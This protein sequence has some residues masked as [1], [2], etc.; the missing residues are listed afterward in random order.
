MTIGP[1][2]KTSVDEFNKR[3]A[4]GHKHQNNSSEGDDN[5]DKDVNLSNN[6]T[7]SESITNPVIQQV[8]STTSTIDYSSPARII[9][10]ERVIEGFECNKES[11]ETVEICVPQRDVGEEAVVV[12]D[13]GLVLAYYLVKHQKRFRFFDEENPPHVVDIGAGTGVVGLVAAGLGAKVTL[14]DLPRILPL[15]EEGILANKSVFQDSLQGRYD[16][17]FIRA[18]PLN[19]GNIGEVNEVSVETKDINEKKVV[20]GP[21]DLI[22]VSDCVYFEASL[23]PLI[24][25]LRE[26]SKSSN[27]SVPILLSYEVRDYSLQKKK[28]KEDFFN[29]A[30]RYFLINEIP[31]KECH[32]EYA[33]EDI[34]LVNM[35]L[36]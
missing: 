8:A 31:T 3:Q 11:Q 14:T 29:L 15:L 18:L 1:G 4:E 13:A 27:K 26:L 9:V 5:V 32:P 10:I 21:P 7:K 12:W 6:P 33:S 17:R 28:V 25:T 16:K 30:S 22:V 35:T 34:K 24:F 19:W 20:G 2:M 36:L 23:A